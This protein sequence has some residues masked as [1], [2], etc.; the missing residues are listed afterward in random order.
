MHINKKGEM[1]F[2]L[3]MLIWALVGLVVVLIILKTQSGK[4]TVFLDW[5]G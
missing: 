3:M 4:F 2:W 1:P 5:L